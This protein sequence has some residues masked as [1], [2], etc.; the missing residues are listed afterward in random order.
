M[1]GL[2]MKYKAQIPTFIFDQWNSSE[3]RYG[4]LECMA[5][6]YTLMSQNITASVVD[7]KEIHP[8]INFYRMLMR[9]HP[10]C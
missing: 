2:W 9:V 6:E 3:S 8:T 4:G 1:Y 10:K 7:G 5:Q